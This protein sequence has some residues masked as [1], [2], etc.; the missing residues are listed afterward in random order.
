MDPSCGSFC[1]TLLQLTLFSRNGLAAKKILEL[2][3]LNSFVFLK[4][5]LKNCMISSQR[6]NFAGFRMAFGDT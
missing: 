6:S 3:F 2:S 1:M 5:A 4:F